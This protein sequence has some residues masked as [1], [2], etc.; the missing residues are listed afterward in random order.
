MISHILWA[1]EIIAVLGACSSVA[2]YLLCLWS[3]TSFLRARRS[4]EKGGLTEVD[5]SAR[6]TPAPVSLLKPLKG[7]DPG[8][9]ES[10]RSQCMQDYPEYEIIFSVSDSADP[11]VGL[12][13]QLQ[14]EFPQRAIRLKVCS[15]NLGANAKVSNLVQM[16]GEARHE[17]IVVSDSDIRVEPDYLRRVIQPLTDPKI[18]LVTC[19]YRGVA[20]STLGSRLESLGISADFVPGVLVARQIERGIRFG[21]GST[22]AFRRR[23]LA[24]IGGFEAIADYLADDYELGK[25]IAGHGLKVELSDAV[26]ETFL[27]SYTFA[28]FIRHQ[29]RWSRTI[30]EAR[31]GGYAGL[32]LTFGL[33]WSLLAL[34]VSGGAAC[35]WGLLGVAAC[36]RLA[37]AVLVG[38]VVLR[39]R[40]TI[41][42]LW[43][44]PL[45][46]LLAVAV[47]KGGLVGH[48][49]TWRGEKF[50]LKNGKLVRFDSEERVPQ[51]GRTG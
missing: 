26:V 39:D 32:L 12:V 42:R 30:R 2:Y 49:I 13:E 21:L 17:T 18:G 24:A 44:L 11:A 38:G 46:D 14:T 10:L 28:E 43:L 37:V 50:R 35:A 29:L 48:T 9:Y 34:L 7:I 4:A 23:D 15:D 45:R 47:W 6:A 25:R 33:P 31:R 8:M 51:P 19:L 1:L 22:L 41:R 27:P 5:G 16:L 3:A 20:A 36:L 40:H